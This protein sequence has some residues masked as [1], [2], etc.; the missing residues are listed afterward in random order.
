MHIPTEDDRFDHYVRS[1]F[2]DSAINPEACQN[3][4]LRSFEAPDYYTRDEMPG[5]DVGQYCVNQGG[6][7]EPGYRESQ[8]GSDT[9]DKDL[10]DHHS[11]TQFDDNMDNRRYGLAQEI[12]DWQEDV[13]KEDGGFLCNDGEHEQA[14]AYREYGE[15]YGG[16]AFA[17]VG[18]FRNNS[19]TEDRLRINLGK[20]FW[21]PH[22]W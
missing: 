2:V 5:F 15:N 17:A 1:K 3:P 9:Y 18:G 20:G 14:E 21:R 6:E 16:H 19:L 22:R 12:C 8:G 4:H 11:F 10:T 13:P 7:Q